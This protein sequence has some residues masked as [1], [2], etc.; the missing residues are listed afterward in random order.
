MT[1]EA[2]VVTQAYRRILNYI[3]ACGASHKNLLFK[4][5]RKENFK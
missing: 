1:I 2:S 4:R 3:K 5:K